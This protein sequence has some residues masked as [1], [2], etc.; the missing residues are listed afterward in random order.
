MVVV[1]VAI[2]DA[3][4]ITSMVLLH[5]SCVQRP[6]YTMSLVYEDSVMHSSFG[7]VCVCVH[8]GGMVHENEA[9]TT[10]DT[11]NTAQSTM[12]MV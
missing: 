7:N 3:I 10:M 6:I 11:T 4:N 5:M 2:A 12:P 9:A 8:V 1:V